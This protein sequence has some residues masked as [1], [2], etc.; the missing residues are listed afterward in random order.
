MKFIFLLFI[1]CS[2]SLVLANSQQLEKALSEQKARDQKVLDGYKKKNPGWQKAPNDAY[3]K[4]YTD[5]ARKALSGELKLRENFCK[6]DKS[7]CPTEKEKKA[8]TAQTN[9]AIGLISMQNQLAKN[10]QIDTATRRKVMNEAERAANITLCSRHNKKCDDLSDVDKKAAQLEI[11]R[12]KEIATLELKFTQS[13]PKAKKGDV[14]LKDFKVDLEKQRLEKTLGLLKELCELNPD[15]AVFCL[16]DKQKEEM[17]VDSQGD[18]CREERVHQLYTIL[19]SGAEEKEETLLSKHDDEWYETLDCKKLLA[20]DK[21]DFTPPPVKEEVKEEVVIEEK[22]PEVIVTP[23][24]VEEKREVASTEVAVVQDE[25]NEDEKSPRN[26]NAETCDWVTDLP[27]RIVHGPSCGR[28]N[29]SI[30]T[31]YVVCDQKVGGGKFVRMS[32][33]GPEY[34]GASKRDAVN[35]TKQGSYFSRKPA[36]E[37][38]EFVTPKL[39]KIFSGAIQE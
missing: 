9:V 34:C 35:C 4:F 14:P 28:Y 1:L 15:D 20:L 33:C 2:S 11:R 23:P 39:K 22:K 19:K 8:S 25:E 3:E 24:P 29:N 12:D 38:R 37:T 36:D 6:T 30:C 27:R 18:E 21:K 16:S 31:G 17:K 10:P 7:L 13:H 32:T 5:W 26:Y